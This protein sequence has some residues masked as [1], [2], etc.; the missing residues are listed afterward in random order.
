MG[1]SGVSAP[2]CLSLPT[3][4]HLAHAHSGQMASLLSAL[5]LESIILC[6]RLRQTWKESASLTAAGGTGVAREVP[7]PPLR[8]P[9]LQRP[10]LPRRDGCGFGLAPDALGLAP[11]SPGSAVACPYSRWLL[12]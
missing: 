5:L 12:C 6:G 4:G 2:V 7:P 9:P 10:P 11:L 8:A 3:A 1:G